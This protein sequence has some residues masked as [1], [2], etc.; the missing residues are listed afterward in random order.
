MGLD[1]YL[2]IDR[3][4]S[5]Y[6]D[7]DKPALTKLNEGI[8]TLVE[9]DIPTLDSRDSVS[10][11][12]GVGY[13]RKANAI[14]NWFVE[15]VQGGV[16]ECQRSFVDPEVLAELRDLCRELIDLFVDESTREIALQEA[17]EKL[18]VAAGFFFGGQEYDGYY[19]DDVKETAEFL[20]Q[21][22]EWHKDNR[23]WSIYYQSSW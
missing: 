5:A 19:W 20:E 18:P 8:G 9:S 16:D 4:V 22:L 3:Y 14:H 21:F 13:W 2:E 11:T 1:M 6:S 7:A 10:V 17:E 12:K 23:M 15:N